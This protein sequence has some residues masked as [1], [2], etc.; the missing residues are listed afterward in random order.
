MNERRLIW[1]KVVTAVTVGLLV[2]DRM[3]LSPAMV[4]WGEQS[5]RLDVLRRNVQEGR[6]LLA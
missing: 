5:E 1:L 2:L 3:V 6:A 4:R